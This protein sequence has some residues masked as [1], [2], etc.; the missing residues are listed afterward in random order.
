MPDDS[1]KGKKNVGKTHGR[2]NDYT[3]KKLLA[4]GAGNDAYSQA[5]TK[6]LRKDKDGEVINDYLD[7]LPETLDDVHVLHDLWMKSR[8][9]LFS[10][11]AAVA[12]WLWYRN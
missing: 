4:I 10:S 7:W 11:G 3:K 9:Q 1:K 6:V 2:Q 12:A 8:V 5:E